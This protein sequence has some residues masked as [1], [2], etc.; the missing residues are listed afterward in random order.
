MNNKWDDRA[1]TLS[2]CAW[3]LQYL[4]RKD[5]YDIPVKK[6]NLDALLHT[7]PKHGMKQ[8]IKIPFQNNQNPFHR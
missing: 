2:M 1:Y 3:Y 6:N 4:R 8:N 7:S 5:Q